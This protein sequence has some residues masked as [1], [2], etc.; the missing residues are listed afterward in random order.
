LLS[1]VNSKTD[2]KSGF[3]ITIGAISVLWLD[4]DENRGLYLAEICADE[5][6][7]NQRT[8]GDLKGFGC[9]QLCGTIIDSI[10]RPDEME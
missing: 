8:S 3:L 7:G 5:V 2:E 1:P 6:I 10:S 9:R 4:D